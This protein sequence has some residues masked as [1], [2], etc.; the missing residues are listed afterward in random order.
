MSAGWSSAAG[1]IAFAG[2]A[3]IAAACMWLMK[4]YAVYD[5]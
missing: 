1:M 5:N 3:L 2:F 4:R